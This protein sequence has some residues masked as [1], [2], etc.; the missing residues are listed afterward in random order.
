MIHLVFFHREWPLLQ[1]RSREAGRDV[2]Q[3]RQDRTERSDERRA[4]RDAQG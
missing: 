1:V 4:R 3:A 2:H